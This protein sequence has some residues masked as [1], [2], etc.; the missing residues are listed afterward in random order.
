MN[1]SEPANAKAQPPSRLTE[2]ILSVLGRVPESDERKS[3]NPAKHARSIA[4]KA[5]AKAALTAGGFA[6]PTGPAGW[7]TIIPELQSVW[8][9]QAQMV[10]DIAAVYGKTK[11]LKQE[12][13]IYCLFKATAAMAVRDVVVRVGERFLVRRASLET[14]QRIAARIG[15]KLTQ[16]AI[17]SSISRFIPILGALGVGAYAYYDTGRVAQTAIDLFETVI[18]VEAEVIPLSE[19]VLPK[20]KP[21]A[22]RTST[23]PRRRPRRRP[24]PNRKMAETRQP[25]GDDQ[26]H[27]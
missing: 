26:G 3:G 21:R 10:S 1:K 22:R 15:M 17:G 24:V 23:T 8:R 12:E 16:R 11:N 13:M 7:L 19:E 5:A 14:L 25:A 6:M 18:D 9:I 4:S 2:I 20:K 27:G